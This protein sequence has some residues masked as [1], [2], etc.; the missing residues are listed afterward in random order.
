MK[1]HFQSADFAAYPLKNLEAYVTKSEQLAM[2]SNKVENQLE[3]LLIKTIYQRWIHREI[4]GEILFNQAVDLIE[5][6]PE[7]YYYYHHF[8]LRVCFYICIRKKDPSRS[9]E[10]LAAVFNDIAKYNNSLSYMKYLFNIASNLGYVNDW[11]SSLH[12]SKKALELANIRNTSDLGFIWNCNNQIVESFYKLKMLDSAWEYQQL[13]NKTFRKQITEE[14]NENLREIVEKYHVQERENENKQ[15]LQKQKNYTIF[16][17]VATFFLIIIALLFIKTNNQ[18]K[19]LKVLNDFKERIYAI[20]SHDLRSPL[21]ALQDLYGQVTY[22]IKTNNL[23][24]LKTI[25]TQ[26][27]E[28]SNNISSLLSN[29]FFWAKNTNT[30]AHK[31]VSNFQLKAQINDTIKLY[32]NI[33]ESKN[34]VLENKICGAVVVSANANVLDLIVRNWIDN[35]L[36]YSQANV[37]EINTTSCNNNVYLNIVDDGTMQAEVLAKIKAQISDKQ[38]DIKLN[39]ANGLGLSF[40]AYFA[41]EVGWQ[42][43]LANTNGKTVFTIDMHHSTHYIH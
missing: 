34:V 5:K 9:Y 6:N 16:I 42:L 27:D 41:K 12:Y 38:L 28:V 29:L 24:D 17:I 21:Y 1:L 19:K 36:K 33:I 37:I 11:Q 25:T 7:Y 3:F 8:V 39:N 43:N 20:I 15:L 35:V 13:A 4:D 32:K 23:N 31:I 40:M 26:I 30:K 18:R 2:A 14:N 10:L 22:L